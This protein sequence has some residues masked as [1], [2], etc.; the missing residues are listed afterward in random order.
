MEWHQWQRYVG[1]PVL[2]P[3]LRKWITV[4]VEYGEV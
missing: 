3:E 4:G 2:A 1:F